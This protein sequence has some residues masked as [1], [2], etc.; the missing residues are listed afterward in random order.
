MKPPK[1]R[2][3]ARDYVAKWLI[4]LRKN[5]SV[6]TRLLRRK[7]LNTNSILNLI[8]LAD[9]PTFVFLGGTFDMSKAL[10]VKET[11]RKEMAV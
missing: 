11:L 8:Y 4:K 9:I 10:E 2:Q 5:N 7:L 3:E 6:S 1:E